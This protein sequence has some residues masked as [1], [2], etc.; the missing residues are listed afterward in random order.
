VVRSSEPRLSGVAALNVEGIL[1]V[2]LCELGF[3]VLLNKLSDLLRLHVRNGTDREL[4]DNL[5]GDHSLVTWVVEGTFNTVKRKGRVSPTMLQDVAFAI[6]NVDL[7][8]NSTVE[9]VHL[10]SQ[11]IVCTLLLL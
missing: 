8:T 9:L 10:E 3:N 5:G 4:A 6:E 7:A 11:V 1:A 2:K